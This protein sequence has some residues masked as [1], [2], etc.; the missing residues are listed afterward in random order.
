[1]KT[2]FCITCCG[3][4]DQLWRTLPSNLLENAHDAQIEFVLVDYSS[5]DGLEAW[6]RGR[7]MGYIKSG[8]LLYAKLD[9]AKHYNSPHSKN[10]AHRLAAGDILVDLN[11][12]TWMP[13]RLSHLIKGVVKDGV[14]MRCGMPSTFGLI[15]M[16]KGDFFGLGGYD[17]R[18]CEGYGF[19]DDSLSHRAEAFGLK[20]I[21]PP[22]ELC[23][24]IHHGDD[25]R[26]ENMVDKDISSSAR[27]NA[28][29]AYLDLALSL[30]HI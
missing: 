17:E 18:L 26:V 12:D 6:V 25:R 30:I 14:Y 11:A 23:T 2:S 29:L 24:C 19:D 7:L 10:L 3:R 16:S 15:A 27:E 28:G 8:R 13:S 1:M 5:R 22:A 4:L 9:G 20:P 21:V